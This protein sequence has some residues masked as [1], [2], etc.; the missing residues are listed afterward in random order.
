[1]EESGYRLDG[2]VGTYQQ[3]DAELLAA[4]THRACR[5]LAQEAVEQLV[6][7]GLQLLPVVFGDGRGCRFLLAEKQAGIRNGKALFHQTAAL[8]FLFQTA[9][10]VC[11]QLFFVSQLP[12]TAFAVGQ[13][14]GSR[15][16]LFFQLADATAR[17][18]LVLNAVAIG[19]GLQLLGHLQTQTHDLA[20]M[21]II[22]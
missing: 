22:E 10:G 11:Q 9:Q 1:M 15:L 4:D 7:L 2:E 8:L 13:L 20:P 21:Q 17:I 3:A 6:G 16:K 12:A 19:L 18:F 5:Q 14:M